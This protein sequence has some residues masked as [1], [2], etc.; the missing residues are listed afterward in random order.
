MDITEKLVG[1]K[2]VRA[3]LAD[4]TLT[5]DDGTVL[6][7]DRENSDCCSYLELMT[8]H[9]TDNLITSA[10]F[11]DDEE[12]LGEGSYSAWLTV[13]TETGDQYAVAEASGSLG[14]G[15]YLHGFALNIEV[16]EA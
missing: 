14:S 13:I 16:I 3:S 7:F 6:K 8:L 12:D 2:I 4:A 10:R 15:Y 1:H 11:E 5:L 9:T